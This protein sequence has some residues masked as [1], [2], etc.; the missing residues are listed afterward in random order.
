MFGGYL[1]QFGLSPMP[2]MGWRKSGVLLCEID[3][4][5]QQLTV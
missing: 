1:W 3:I 5:V 4:L 2:P